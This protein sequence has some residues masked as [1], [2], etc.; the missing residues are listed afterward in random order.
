[1][2]KL[3]ITLWTIVIINIAANFLLNEFSANN[4]MNTVERVVTAD[5]ITDG[6]M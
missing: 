3:P 1:M 4:M 5:P 2:A 6:P